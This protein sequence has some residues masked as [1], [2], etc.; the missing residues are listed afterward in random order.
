MTPEE[1][2]AIW[3]PED[4]VWSPWAKPV[5]F[6]QPWL[7]NAGTASA[8]P[9]EQPMDWMHLP[10]DGIPLA[11]DTAL[12][13]DLSGEV[14][15]AYGVALAGRGYCPVPLFNACSGPAELVPIQPILAALRHGARDLAHAPSRP[16]AAPPAFLL[17]ANRQRGAHEVRPGRFDNRS[18]L[19][20]QDFPSATFL[21]AQGIQQVL[22]LQVDRSPIAED[23]AHVLL[24]WQ[25]AGLTILRCVPLLREPPEPCRVK[26]PPSFRSA[27]YRAM[28]VMGLRRNS[29]GGFGSVV[30]M[31]SS[32]G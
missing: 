17:D 18:L 10:C 1:L 11:G 20:P 26:R 29:A 24:R 23:L 21:R 3:A 28:A 14:S 4:S 31:P 22:V 32:G 8:N 19:F 7:A 13:V 15:A 6:V 9:V 5:C 30:P 16:P 12:V 25:Q 27:W 2:F